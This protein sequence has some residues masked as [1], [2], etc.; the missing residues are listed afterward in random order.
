MLSNIELSKEELDFVQK[1]Y[2]NFGQESKIIF[3]E[4]GKVRKIFNDSFGLNNLEKE[5]KEE[6]RENKLRKMISLSQNKNFHNG[7]TPIATLSFEKKFIGVD[8]TTNPNFIEFGAARLDRKESLFYLKLIRQKLEEFHQMGIV[9]GD[10]RGDNILIDPEE[11]TVSF[12]DLDNMQ[13]HNYPINL[14]SHILRPFFY[15]GFLDEK[16]DVFMYN[17]LLIDALDNYYSGYQEI[18]HAL[19]MGYQP[20]YLIREARNILEQIKVGYASGIYRGP[21]LDSY[22]KVKIKGFKKEQEYQKRGI[23]N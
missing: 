22:V 21:Y 19:E 16:A 2:Q 4:S 1:N 5:E 14:Q 23:Y 8:L 10:L 15:D 12:C 20:N 7:I 6:I 11:Q 18:I 13:I 3:L 17:L 9:Y